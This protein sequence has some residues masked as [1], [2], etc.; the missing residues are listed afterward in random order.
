MPKHAFIAPVK[1]AFGLVVAAVTA[2]VFL[3]ATTA[4]GDPGT[5]EASSAT[6]ANTPWG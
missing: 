4:Q 6:T 2:T 1:T 3:G 5:P